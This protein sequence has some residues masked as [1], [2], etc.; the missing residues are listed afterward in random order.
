M[1]IHHAL[2]I[3]NKDFPNE[4]AHIF[5]QC[6]NGLYVI[7]NQIKHPTL[8]NNHPDKTILGEIVNFLYKDSNPQHYIT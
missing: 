8:H 7:Q 4:P 1:A 3:I 2:T 5:T 6:L